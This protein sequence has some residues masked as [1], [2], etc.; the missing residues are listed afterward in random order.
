MIVRLR[1][2]SPLRLPVRPSVA[3]GLLLFAG[4]SKTI[5]STEPLASYVAASTDAKA[6][7]WAMI[8][9]SGPTQIPVAA[10]AAQSDPGYQAELAS[11]ESAQAAITADQQTAVTYWSAGGALRW[12]EE[13]RQLVARQDLPP[14]PNPDGS[15]PSPNPAN[16]FA[17][18]QF[19]FSN[20]PY[21]ARAYSYVAVAQYEALKVAW[22]YKYLYNRAAP[23][24]NDS[25]LKA[26]LPDNHIPA[27]PSEDA[28]EAAVNAAMLKLLFPT[29]ATEIDA[30]AAQQEQV[31]MLAGRASASDVA[32]GVAIGQA[33]AAIVSARAGSDGFKSAAGN[34]ALWAQLASNAT[35]RGEV[36]WISQDG[37]PRPPM[38][39]LFGS[40]KTWMMQASDVIAERPAAPPG[41]HSAAMQSEL[42]TVRDAVNNI[43]RDQLATVYKWAD[44]V[45]TPTPPGHWDT[46]AVPY[47]EAAQMSEVRTARTFALLNMALHDAGVACW[48]AKYLYFNPRPSQLDPSIKTWTGL[49]N[50]PAYVSGHSDFSAAGADVLSYIFP[51]GATYFSAQAQEAAMSR[52][53]GG[54]HYPSDISAGLTQGKNVG[55]YTV[56]FAKTDGAD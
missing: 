20:P 14:S 3:L 34:A 36:P 49:P 39:P 29:S 30:L 25:K 40:V 18:P 24:Q 35:A 19:P 11:L 53:Y 44:G 51:S 46:I 56:R 45:S 21:A 37:P 22:Y 13:L 15:Y 28:T 48:D 23:F 8:L 4:C 41:T 55:E 6:G 5:T 42:A 43:T 54:I 47:I 38:L 32:A 33:V 31:A 17:N 7:T 9:L 2:L 16:P 12:N 27:F 52:L 50:F 10:P 26:L 1:T